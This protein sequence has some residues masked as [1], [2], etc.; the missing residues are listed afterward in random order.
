MKIFSPIELRGVTFKNRIWIPPMVMYSAVD[1]VVGL[2]HVGHIA[3]FAAGGAGLVICE[4]TAVVPEGRISTACAG[5]WDAETAEAWRPVVEVAHANGTKIGIQL[6][7]A[8]RKGSKHPE[9][10]KSG[11]VELSEGGWR[12][13]SPSA[14]A[15]GAYPTPHALT[16][17]EIAELVVAYRESALRAEAVGFDVVEIHSAHGYLLH[18]FL[19]PLVNFRTDGYGGSRE[20]RARFLFEIVDAIRNV[21][22]MPLFV[23]I[24]ATDWAEGGWDV[25]DSIWLATELKQRGVDLMDI[26]T[27]GA[28]PEQKVLAG[29]HFQVP[30]AA[31]IRAAVDIPTS[32]VGLITEPAAAAEVVESGQADVVMVGRAALRNPHWPWFAAETLGAEIDLPIQYR[33]GQR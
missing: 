21:T 13:D 12:I 3:A 9:I 17:A 20:N 16:E 24:S 29:P 28:V 30:F 10:I 4:A 25:N 2:W 1:G 31:A 23:R 26:S 8:G 27:A 33:R 5:I 7:H 22:Q 15:Y 6:A 19:S 14:V 32:A 18:E 11:H